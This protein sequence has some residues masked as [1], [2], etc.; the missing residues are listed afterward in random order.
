MHLFRTRIIVATFG[1][2]ALLPAPRSL[3]AD[4]PKEVVA[5]F[6]QL[7]FEGHRLSSDTYS[8]IEPLIMYPAE[9]GWDTMLGVQSFKISGEK[10]EGNTAKVIVSYEIDRSWPED[11]GD[12]SE[13]K[14]ETFNL[15]RVNSTWRISE[16]VVYPRVSTD[17]LCSKYKFCTA[18]ANNSQERTE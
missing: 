11:V 5:R 7:D 1:I 18:T 4:T 16:Y 6:C 3:A 9:P 2:L 8:P 13:Y 12:T 15:N 17:L 14:S 10:I